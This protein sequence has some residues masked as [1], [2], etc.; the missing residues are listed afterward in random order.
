MP[1]QKIRSGVWSE[2]S[3]RSLSQ[4]SPGLCPP[5]PPEPSSSGHPFGQP[6]QTVVDICG[7]RTLTLGPAS[8][9]RPLEPPLSGPISRA[10]RREFVLGLSK[11]RRSRPRCATLHARHGCG[12]RRGPM[13]RDPR[14][15][16]EA[17]GLFVK[18]SL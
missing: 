18:W 9:G 11:T 13:S 5:T 1:H 12:A 16:H 15:G 7:H 8:P 6:L 3:W 14:A 10:G 2:K 17:M 4:A